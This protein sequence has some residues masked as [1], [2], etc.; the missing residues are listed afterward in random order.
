ME[1]PVSLS[2]IH[3]AIAAAF[4]LTAL[5]H[6]AVHAEAPPEPTREFRGAW[7]ASVFNIDWPSKP[8]LAVDIQQ[9]ELRNIMD[10]AAS[11][12]LNAILLQVRPSADALYASKREPWSQFLT[13]KQGRAPSPAYD[14][15]EFAIS[16]AHARGL[17]LHAWFNPFRALAST[18]S[19][20]AENHVTKTHP[21]W[22]RNYGKLVW[23]DPG[24]PAARKWSIDTILDVTRRYD[25]DGIHID[26]YFYPYP[27]KSGGSIVPFPDEAPWA[28]YQKSG[29]KLSRDDWRR[30]NINTFM[31]DLYNGIKAEKRWVKFGVS[32]FGIWR[33]GVPE[34]IEAQLDAFAQLYADARLWMHEGWGDYFTPQLYW[35]IA[36][37]KQSFPVLLKWWAA[38]NKARRHMWPGISSAR[39]GPERPATEMVNQIALTRETLGADPGHIHWSLKALKNN[40]GGVADLMKGTSYR[41]RALVP[42]S[43]W[44]G[45]GAPAAPRVARDG[46]EISIKAEKTAGLR[47]WAVQEKVGDTWR[48]RVVPSTATQI[49]RTEGATAVAV[50]AVDV[51]GNAS[52][53]ATLP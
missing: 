22:I 16:E 48:L 12:G 43:P 37:A 44:L 47:W 5:V 28:A 20:V 3:R 14:P 7:V 38:E 35:S 31:R 25:V 15:L 4:A 39:V 24:D 1:V 26:D 6:S 27:I 46:E 42:A 50:R 33:P 40:V 32:P 11:M 21:E 19:P 10:R 53:P 8:G 49:K 18:S 41:D 23:L 17:E 13:G 45:Q 2:R 30:D 9:A 52:A 51:V 36:P 34:T 29:G